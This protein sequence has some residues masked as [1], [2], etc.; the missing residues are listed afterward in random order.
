MFTYLN[1]AFGASFYDFQSCQY[2]LLSLNMTNGI[3]KSKI[4]KDNSFIY[5][6]I[7]IWLMGQAIQIDFF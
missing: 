2:R 1:S 3:L 4:V 7:H 5:R 6:Y